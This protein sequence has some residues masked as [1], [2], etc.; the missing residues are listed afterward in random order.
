[1]WAGVPNGCPETDSATGDTA[2]LGIG[3]GDH[4][5]R[6]MVLSG[7]SAPQTDYVSRSRCR[8]RSA[9]CQ[10]G[11]NL[12][13]CWVMCVGACRRSRSGRSPSARKAAEQKRCDRPLPGERPCNPPSTASPGCSGSATPTMV[14]IS[15]PSSDAT[16]VTASDRPKRLRQSSLVK[17]T[18]VSKVDPN[19]S[20][21]TWRARSLLERDRWS[22]C[23][24]IRSTRSTVGM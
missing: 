14:P 7:S 22:S 3:I 21:A 12:R 23:G 16:N 18:S 2:R 10:R 8:T 15:S 20:G 17:V 1:M 5:P 9:Q 13:S 11:S 24:E 4:S 19:E 6:V